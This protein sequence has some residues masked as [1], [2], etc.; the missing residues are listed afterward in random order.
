[1]AKPVMQKLILV[2]INKSEIIMAKLT[3]VKLENG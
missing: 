2:K 1:M 3:M